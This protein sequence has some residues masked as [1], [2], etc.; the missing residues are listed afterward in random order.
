MPWT[1]ST[2]QRL[3]DSPALFGEYI[4]LL[5]P[6]KTLHRIYF[7]FDGKSDSC[8]RYLETWKE[9]LPDYEI[10]H[11][12]AENLPMDLNP[13]VRDL[14]TKR[15]HA[16]LTDYFRWWVL[17]EHGGV[18][19]DAD[20]EIIDGPNLDHLI[21]ELQNS[22]TVDAIIGIDNKSSGWYTA[23]SMAS[24]PNSDIT[25]FMCNVYEEMG[26]L[27]AWRKKA[28]YLWAPQLTALYFFEHDHH[29]DG[30]GTSP[31]LDYP[32]VAARV[33]IYPQDYFSPI[34]PE[35]QANG[36]LFT[37]NGYTER[38][39]ICHHFACSWHD[40]KSLYQSASGRVFSQWQRVST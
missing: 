35:T 21:D 15:D 20:V 14:Y 28:F 24:K 13:Y 25:K 39:V 5:N 22:S 3:R 10:R 36:D 26:P 31:N 11:W 37:I 19:L 34:V 7:G 6:L 18:Y 23:H 12:N 32:I 16:F 38:T 27:R 1:D 4:K 33:K 2:K 9:Q 17:R 8:A 40:S 30:M 29:V